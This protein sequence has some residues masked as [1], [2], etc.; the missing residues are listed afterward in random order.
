M[1]VPAPRKPGRPVRHVLAARMALAAAAAS[2]IIAALA[3]VAERKSIGEVAVERAVTAVAALKALIEDEGGSPDRLDG[4]RVQRAL[5]R[6]RAN[7]IGQESGRFVSAVVYDGDGRRIAGIED[8]AAMAAIGTPPAGPAGGQAYVYSRSNGVPVVSLT[9]PILKRDGSRAGTASGILA[10][11]EGAITEATAR[12]VRR[13]LIAIGIVL[14]TTIIIYPIIARLVYR[15]HRSAHKLLDSNLDSI[16]ALGS[17]IAKK[18]SDTDIHNYRVTIYAARLGEAAGLDRKAMCALMKGAFLHD[19]GKIGIPDAIL[20]KPGRLDEAEFV[21]MKRHVEYGLEIVRHSSW[22]AD[23]ADVV[24]AHHEKFDGSGYLHGLRGENIPVNARIFAIADVF[25]AL[26]S[27]RPYKEPMSYEESIRIIESGSGA[28]FDPR[29]FEIFAGIARP[30]YDEFGNRDDERP[31]AVLREMIDY[32]F[33]TDDE[34]LL[35]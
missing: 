10:V 22:L 12:I 2:V 7:G 20:L 28:H 25:D 35:A 27:R 21:E 8:A 3:V 17:A 23:A 34:I 14:A 33:K 30:L 6:L 19:I 31:R 16:A 5:D 26:T 32:Y 29:L 24:G 13:V 9:V 15:L 11:S 1:A 4:A 18:D